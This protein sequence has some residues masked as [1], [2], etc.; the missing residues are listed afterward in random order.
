MIFSFHNEDCFFAIGYNDDG[1]MNG[2]TSEQKQELKEI[3]SGVF[4]EK[5]EPFA[6][7]IQSDLKNIREDMRSMEARISERLKVIDERLLRLE[8]DVSYLRG[9]VSLLQQEI[10]EIR[11]FLKG[12]VTKE[13]VEILRISVKELETRLSKMEKIAAEKGLT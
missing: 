5:L 8:D 7:A 9:A 11:D 13:E 6:M 4:D 10:L 3:V 2:F 1:N 12:V